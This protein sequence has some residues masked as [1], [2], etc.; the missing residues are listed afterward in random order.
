M[1]KDR[2]LT[3]YTFESFMESLELPN[4]SKRGKSSRQKKIETSRKVSLITLE[5]DDRQTVERFYLYRH[6]FQVTLILLVFLCMLKDLMNYKVLIDKQHPS[7][8][9]NSFFCKLWRCIATSI[10][11]AYSRWRTRRSLDQLFGSNLRKEKDLHPNGT[12]QQQETKTNP[13]VTYLFRI[14]LLRSFGN[15]V[16]T[17][18]FLSLNSNISVTFSMISLNRCL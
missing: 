16:K 7:P 4:R 3:L 8:L 6:R 17:S 13:L 5:K 10:R 2:R 15:T 12:P 18:T 9:E 14:L 11:K 1:V